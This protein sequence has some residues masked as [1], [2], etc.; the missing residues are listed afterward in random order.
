MVLVP[1]I[2]PVKTPVP[3]TIVKLPGVPL[4]HVPVVIPGLIP[5]VVELVPHTMNDV[6]PVITGTALSV[7]TTVEVQPAPG[8]V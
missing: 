3:E 2:T 7:T 6:V 5:K 4:A 8:V 1:G